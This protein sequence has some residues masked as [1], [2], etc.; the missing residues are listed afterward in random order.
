MYANWILVGVILVYNAGTG[1][2]G[3]APSS[4][5]TYYT[6]FSSQPVVDNTGSFTNTNGYTFGGWNTA[7]NGSGISYPV[8]SNVTLP[9]GAGTT[10]YAQWI[11]PATQYTLTYDANSAAGG[12]GTAPAP[13]IS[14]NSNATATILGN[15]GPYTNSDPT[16][17][18]YNWNTAVD[19]TG[20]SYQSGSQAG[21]TIT[22][23]ADKTLYAQWASATPQ[24][25]V[26]YDAN[27]ATGG[28]VPA[29]PT[30]YPTN[31]QVPILNLASLTRSGYTFLGWNSSPTGAGSVYIPGY[32]FISKTVTLYALWA[33]GSPIRICGSGSSGASVGS[34][35]VTIEYYFPLSQIV[36]SS[37]TITVYSTVLL[38]GT[39]TSN[40]GTGTAP[41][42]INSIASK[43]VITNSTIT[44]NTNTSYANQANDHNYSK[45]IT[46]GSDVTYWPSGANISNLTFSTLTQSNSSPI[47]TYNISTKTSSSG[48]GLTTNVFVAGAYPGVNAYSFLNQTFT[49]IFSNGSSTFIANSP[50]NVLYTLSTNP[51]TINWITAPKDRYPYQNIQ[52]SYNALTAIT[53]IPSGGST[54]VNPAMPDYTV[55]YDGNGNTSGFIPNPQYMAPYVPGTTSITLRGFATLAKAGFTFSGW[56]TAANGTGTSYAVS[57]RYNGGASLILYAKWT[58]V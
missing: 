53:V 2:S 10:L 39:T 22:M 15:I 28:S 58:P 44:I 42:G 25:T 11:N 13:S 31:V 34:P 7:A 41:L 27:G 3:T 9:S 56:N 30:N 24:Y 17:I 29:A 21:S 1:G 6:V 26:T 16:K 12:S 49:I 8:G 48:C 20:T 40:Y 32:T 38:R 51:L 18:F 54:Y 55:Q 46:N 35:L 50:T 5:G 23:I 19:G 52:D 47:P 33:P 57:A 45:T 36:R 4:S 14:Y 43:T 37:D